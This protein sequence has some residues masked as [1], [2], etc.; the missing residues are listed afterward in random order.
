MWEFLESRKGRVRIFIALGVGVLVLAA[1]SGSDDA[2][3]G[4]SEDFVEEN[5]SIEVARAA[6]ASKGTLGGGEIDESSVAVISADP[7]R[8]E[9]RIIRDGRVDIRIEPGTFDTSAAQ[10]RT[11]AADLGGYIAQGQTRLEEADDVK[12]MTGWYTLRIP[13]DRF[14]EALGRLDGMGERLGV[15]LSSQ[16]VTEEF[17]DLEGRLRYWRD[18]EQF[19]ERLLA[20]AT[21]INDLVTIQGRMQ[22]VLLNIESIEGR[23]RYLEDR[24]S[25]STLTVGLT[26]VPGATPL[27]PTDPT[28]V[29]IIQDALEQA[30]A[31]LL[32]TIGFMI[33]A[34]AFVLPVAGVA[35]IVLFVAKAI[36]ASTRRSEKQ[37]EA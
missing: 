19:Y 37:A 25:L 13:E 14:E 29:G 4:E 27:T 24:T 10:L 23:L 6:E 1:C 7:V 18:Q 20:E 9:P 33:V 11:L 34:A 5:E 21:T 26:E 15:N 8:Y 28:E 12:Y 30:G 32:G 35:L 17:V 31:V 2:A 22:E 36:L 3:T 16:D